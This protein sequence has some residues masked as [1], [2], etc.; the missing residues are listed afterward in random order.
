MKCAGRVCD[1]FHSKSHVVSRIGAKKLLGKMDP[2]GDD[3][4]LKIFEADVR[5][6]HGEHVAAVCF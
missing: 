4:K 3:L 5:R 1:N 6:A 2:R